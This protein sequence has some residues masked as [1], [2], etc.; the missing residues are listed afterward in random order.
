MQNLQQLRNLV[1]NSYLVDNKFK[2]TLS[3][4]FIASQIAILLN[5]NNNLSKYYN[6]HSIINSTIEYFVELSGS[7]VIGCVGL[8]KELKMDK[9]VHLSVDYSMRNTGIGNRLLNAAVL[10]SL[11]DTLYMSIRNDNVASINLANKIGFSVI[12][13]IPKQ[14]YNI[15]T[16]CLFR[17][18]DVRYRPY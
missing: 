4:E 7:K 15:F 10:N 13:Y 1:P 14:T 5:N 17:R 12:A 16:L 8:K 3:D 11:K 2:L 18:N 9:I 6:T